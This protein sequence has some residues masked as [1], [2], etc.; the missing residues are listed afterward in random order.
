M[1]KKKKQTELDVKSIFDPIKI[2]NVEIKNRI[3]WL[4]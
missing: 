3:A 1:G 2:G 4:R